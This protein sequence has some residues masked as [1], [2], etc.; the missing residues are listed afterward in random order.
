MDSQHSQCRTELLGTGSWGWGIRG[1][2]AG[3]GAGA[4]AE[5]SRRGGGKGDEDEEGRMIVREGRMEKL[6]WGVT[7][8][9]GRKRDGRRMEKSKREVK[10][11]EGEA[12]SRR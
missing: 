5:K 10:R 1:G 8:K 7:I 6:W 4:G 3:A 11:I 9:Y 2:G 12:G